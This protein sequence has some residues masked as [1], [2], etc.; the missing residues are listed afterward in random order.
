VDEPI[1][2][3]WQ[4]TLLTS[5]ICTII[6][7]VRSTTGDGVVGSFRA[8]EE[9]ATAFYKKDFRARVSLP[10]FCRDRERRMHNVEGY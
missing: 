1:S 4:K 2:P 9:N 7:M 6:L 5:G 8:G 3:K 10:S